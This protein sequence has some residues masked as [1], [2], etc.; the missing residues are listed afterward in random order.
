MER[1]SYRLLRGA[2]PPSR[3]TTRTLPLIDPILVERRADP[4][5]HPD[6]VFEPKYDGYRGMLY[7]APGVATFG[8]KRATSWRG[9]ACSRRRS[10]PNSECGTRF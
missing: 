5:S 9:S 6:W 8:S 3:R 10:M 2:M 7:L 4:F 1:A